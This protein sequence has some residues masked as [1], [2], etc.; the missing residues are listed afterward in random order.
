[1]D[2]PWSIWATIEKLRMR[3]SEVFCGVFMGPLIAAN[4][5]FREDGL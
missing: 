5:P 4:P 2:L 3:E 1:V